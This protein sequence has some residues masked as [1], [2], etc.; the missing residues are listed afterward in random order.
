MIEKLRSHIS[1][2][3][4]SISCAHS[5]SQ[6]PL[7]PPSCHSSVFSLLL[8]EDG[9]LGG[10]SMDILTWRILTFLK[11]RLNDS[12]APEGQKFHTTP[13]VGGRNYILSFLLL[14]VKFHFLGLACLDS[15]EQVYTSTILGQELREL[16]W[17]FWVWLYSH[18]HWGWQHTANFTSLYNYL[19][20]AMPQ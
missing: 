5:P 7:Q 16:G 12:M 6:C 15:M 1:G 2:D 8:P 13:S 11:P 4:K 17:Q 10:R 14:K 9:V 18:F 3:Y 20:A 19:A